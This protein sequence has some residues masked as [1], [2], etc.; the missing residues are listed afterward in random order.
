MVPRASA[1]K[2][3]TL[4]Q[5]SSKMLL[6]SSGTERKTGFKPMEIG[7]KIYY[8][9]ELQQTGSCRTNSCPTI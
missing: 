5:N 2:L 3:I 9:H 4:F 1:Q 6:N 8:S 7:L